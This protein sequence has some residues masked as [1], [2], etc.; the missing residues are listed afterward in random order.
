VRRSHNQFT[1]VNMGRRSGTSARTQA[2]VKAAEAV[3]RRDAERIAR[4]KKLQAVLADFYHAQSEV[5]RVRREAD[6]ATAP[7]DAAMRDAVRALN[8][9]DEGRAGIAQ[10]TGLPPVRVRE[11]L[12]DASLVT[13]TPAAGTPAAE[14][15]AGVHRVSG[16]APADPVSPAP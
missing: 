8:A 4:E 12:A 13:A 15:S 3:A 16:A 11:Y 7:F 6:A 1:L 14:A 2:L 5:E 10:L 9:L